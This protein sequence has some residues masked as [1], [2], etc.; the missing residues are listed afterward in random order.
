M[1]EVH[2]ARRVLDGFT[3]A[4]TL[5]IERVQVIHEKPARPFR[6]LEPQYRRELVRVYLTSVEASTRVLEERGDQLAKFQ[7]DEAR[8]ADM[9]EFLGTSQGKAQALLASEKADVLLKGIVKR[10]FNEKEVTSLHMARCAALPG[11]R[12]GSS[13]DGAQAVHQGQE[14]LALRLAEQVLHRDGRPRVRP[15]RPPTPTS[16]PAAARRRDAEFRRRGE[17]GGQ[18]SRTSADEPSRCTRCRTCSPSR[19][20]WRSR[21]RGRSRCRRRSS[22][23]R[24]RRSESPS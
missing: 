20:R 11:A 15:E 5:V 21:R 24:R 2:G 17:R 19:S 22:P 10:F 6:C 14:R 16:T 13:A 4:D 1:E 7:E 23:R 9:R 12:I 8:W 18:G 3:V